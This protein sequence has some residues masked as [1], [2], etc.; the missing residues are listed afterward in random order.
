MKRCCLL[1]MLS[2]TLLPASAQKAAEPH[3]SN[4]STAQTPITAYVY[5]PIRKGDHFIRMGLQMGVPLFNTSAKKFAI[6]TNIYPGGSIFLGY[7]YYLNHGISLGGDLAFS[8]YPTL[9]SNLYFSVPFTFNTGYTFAITKFRIPLTFGIG[10][11][12]Q[13][14]NNTR[15]FSLFFRPQAGFFYQYSPEWSF[16]GE[17]SWDIVPQWYK[18][19]KFNRIGNF[20]N[21]GF[22]VRYHF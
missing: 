12:Y 20:L 3:E 7:A 14:Y 9:G 11:N 1:L 22:A 18:D 21:L 19:R 4:T 8:F 2:I 13:A 15:Y 16:G 5:E 6:K 10:G 17:L